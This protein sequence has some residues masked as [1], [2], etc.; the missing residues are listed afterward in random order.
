[1][2][3]FWNSIVADTVIRDACVIGAEVN[4]VVSF[5]SWVKCRV[6]AALAAGEKKGEIVEG[7]M[8]LH[9]HLGLELP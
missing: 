1:M 9:G 7:R 6:G 3:G 2:E 8:R 4:V 5:V